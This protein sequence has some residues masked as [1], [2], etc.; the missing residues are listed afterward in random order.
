V[1]WYTCCTRAAVRAVPLLGLTIL[2]TTTTPCPRWH[3]HQL[4]PACAPA[5]PHAAGCVIF[6]LAS[7]L[8]LTPLLGALPLMLLPIQPKA[9]ALVSNGL[10]TCSEGCMPRSTA[11]HKCTPS[12]Q[13]S[14]T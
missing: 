1:L 7:I 10:H 5:A 6:G 14:S 4:S 2:L 13:R 3:S 9:L 12:L 11:R 8:L